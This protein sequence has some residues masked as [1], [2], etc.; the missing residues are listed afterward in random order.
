[1]VVNL[2]I[3]G[4]HLSERFRLVRDIIIFALSIYALYSIQN[5]YTKGVFDGISTGINLNSC[6]NPLL[7]T[8][9]ETICYQTPNCT[10]YCNEITYE[11]KKLDEVNMSFV[12]YEF[13]LKDVKKYCLN[14]LS[15]KKF[16]VVE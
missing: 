8:Y 9:K 14:D 15:G 13:V 6:F 1:M 7:D 4:A 11:R 5:F 16:M 3:L 2:G 10:L 12:P